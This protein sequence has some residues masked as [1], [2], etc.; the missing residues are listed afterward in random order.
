MAITTQT[1]SI[2]AAGKDVM[3]FKGRRLDDGSAVIDAHLAGHAVRAEWSTDAA[4]SSAEGTK[5][6]V[7]VDGGAAESLT[8]S[9]GVLVGPGGP[10]EPALERGAPVSITPLVEDAAT[11]APE[12]NGGSTGGGGS[13]FW[14]QI[15]QAIGAAIGAAAG[16][17]AGAVIGAAIGGALGA[18]ADKHTRS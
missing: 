7:S 6:R 1:L 11:L 5:V 10:W 17:P 8:L 15:G 12:T 16:G 9:D 3:A 14:Q 4:Q 2:Q 18:Y 13:G